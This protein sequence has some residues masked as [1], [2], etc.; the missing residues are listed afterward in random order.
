MSTS[1]MTRPL[2]RGRTNQVKEAEAQ[3]RP[4]RRWPIHLFIIIMCAIWL[5]PTFALLVSSFRP[6]NLI[7]TTGWWTAPTSFR[8]SDAS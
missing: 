8:Y 3:F 1:E 5:L 4:F 2:E 7:A 6:A